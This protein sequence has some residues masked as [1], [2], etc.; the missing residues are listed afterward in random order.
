MIVGGFAAD[1]AL[2]AALCAGAGG[3][4]GAAGGQGGVRGLVVLAP[5]LLSA[6]GGPDTADDMLHDVS[7]RRVLYLASRYLKHIL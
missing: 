4:G 3:Q 6:E 2:A 5:P 7:T 1:A